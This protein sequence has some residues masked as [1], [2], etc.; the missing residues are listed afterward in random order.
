MINHKYIKKWS[1]FI[2]NETLKTNN[3]NF[4]LNNIEDELKLSGINCSLSKNINKLN[5]TIYNFNNYFNDSADF[6]IMFD[7]LNSLIEMVGFHQKCTF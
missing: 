5:L 7:Y 3:I 6:S 4:T 2:L 1:D